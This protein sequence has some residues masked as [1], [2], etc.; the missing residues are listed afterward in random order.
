MDI[1][2][3]KQ[4]KVLVIGDYCIDIF[5]YGTCERLSPEAPVP[6]FNYKYLTKTDGM[7]GNVVNNLK[8]LNVNAAL[9][10][11]YSEIIKERL[12]DLKSKQHIVRIDYEQEIEP[13]K[14]ESIRNIN[15]YDSIIISDYNKGAINDTLIKE[16]TKHF[17]GP[18]F[19]DTKKQD[20]SLFENCIIKINEPEYKRVKKFPK[21][22]ELIVTMGDKGASYKDI[23]YPSEKVQVFDVSGAGDSFLSGLC[24]QYLIKKDL[25]LSIKFANICASNV[26]KKT[27]TA[28]VDFDE[29]KNE[30][31]F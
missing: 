15:S 9:E 27:G 26:I 24:V 3:L 31:C 23:I 2:L 25:I 7:A 11:S 16:V 8:S 20:L 4:L 6:V 22:Y 13:V 10:T 5:K 21:N 30:L 14:F 19:V 1:Q 12:I 18:I 28:T 17:K 29:V